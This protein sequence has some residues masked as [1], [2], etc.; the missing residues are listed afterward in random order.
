MLDNECEWCGGSG[1]E[2]NPNDPEYQDP[3]PCPNWDPQP[4]RC[5][6][7]YRSDLIDQWSRE[8]F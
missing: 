8:R 4:P 7:C 1:I 2:P 5:R 3:Y 6:E